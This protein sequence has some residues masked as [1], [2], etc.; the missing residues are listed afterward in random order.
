VVIKG[1]DPSWF[2]SV[3]GPT[4]DEL[5]PILLDE[6]CDLRAALA[7]P[8]A[9][10]GEFNLIIDARDENKPHVNRRTMGMFRRAVNDLELKA[11]T[12]L[13]RCYTWNNEHESPMLERIDIWFCSMDWD[14]IFHDA[15]L[16]ALSSLLSDHCLI[17]L[18]L[19]V[20]V[21]AQRCFC[22]ER[23]WSKVEIFLVAVDTSQRYL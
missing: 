14:Y 4:A 20:R 23:F 8:W 13:G 10:C 21:R 3:Y 2:T 18:S 1:G 11:A 16:N 7:G 12:L 17:L 22:F 15:S 5:K 19:A 6:L 9:V